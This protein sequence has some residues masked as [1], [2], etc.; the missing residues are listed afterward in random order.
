MDKNV[1]LLH[2]SL[3]LT[4]HSNC[5]LEGSTQLINLRYVTCHKYSSDSVC[6]QVFFLQHQTVCDAIG[7]CVV[8]ARRLVGDESAI[9][10]HFSIF[11][12]YQSV[13]GECDSLLGL[14]KQQISVNVS[15]FHRSDRHDSMT[16]TSVC[17]VIIRWLC[18]NLSQIKISRIS[19]FMIHYM[20]K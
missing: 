7:E 3:S 13:F 12:N 5:R 2:Q 14:A 15:I 17:N 16:P 19:R 20:R 18:R 9:E 10:L 6:A 8:M 1:F 11:F 4:V